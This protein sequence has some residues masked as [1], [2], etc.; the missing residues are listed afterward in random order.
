MLDANLKSQ[1]KVYLE[2][3]VLPFQI[4]VSLDESAAAKEML[5]LLQDIVELYDKITL[6]TDGTDARKPSFTLN[7]LG[8]ASQIRFAAVPMGDMSSPLS[9]WRFCRLGATRRKS[10]LN[11]SSRSSS[12]TLT[13]VSNLRVVDL[14]QLPRCR[15]SVEPDGGAQPTCHERRDRRRPLSAGSGRPPSA[16][17]AH[18]LLERCALRSGTYGCGISTSSWC[19]TTAEQRF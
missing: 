11:S 14:P 4:T 16:G 7:R 3:V 18:G 2:R 6:K 8:E 15:A 9:Y 12:S 10:R 1:L 13:S 5:G 17:C 19:F